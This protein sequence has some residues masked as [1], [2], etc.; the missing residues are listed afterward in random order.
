MIWKKKW[1]F[2]FVNLEW[3]LLISGEI[4]N[5]EI[6]FWCNFLV[7][8]GLLILSYFNICECKVLFKI[9]VGNFFFVVFNL[10]IMEYKL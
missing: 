9:F 10:I 3:C 5:G 8:E 2:F 4:E 6:W 1:L 7:R